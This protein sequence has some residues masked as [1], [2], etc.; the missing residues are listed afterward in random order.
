MDDLPRQKLSELIATYGRSVCDD[1]RRCE[2]LLRDLCGEHRRE[3]NVLVS[4][5]RERIPAELLSMS[6]ATPREVVLARL[7]KRL[8]DD[9]A[10]ADNAARWAVESWAVAL[11][12]VP[13]P[14]F[15][16]QLVPATPVVPRTPRPSTD[17]AVT[18]HAP[19]VPNQIQMAQWRVLARKEQSYLTGQYWLGGLVIAAGIIAGVVWRVS[20]REKSWFSFWIPISMISGGM[21]ILSSAR[22]KAKIKFLPKDC[23]QAVR[24]C[25]ERRDKASAIGILTGI[26]GWTSEDAKRVVEYLAKCPACQGSG[27]VG[28]NKKCRACKGT[29]NIGM[30]PIMTSVTCGSGRTGNSNKDSL[31]L[32]NTY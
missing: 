16:K 3:L 24:R 27:R 21:Q 1:S 25:L 12:V 10:L 30:D 15:V 26:P 4:A 19:Q 8:Q 23:R 5:L 32:R 13:R 28:L 17:T 6:A 14:G 7:T 22:F 9:L 31:D 2:A 11:G 29:G 20:V 18:G